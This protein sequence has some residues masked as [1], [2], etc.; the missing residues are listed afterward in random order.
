MSEYAILKSVFVARWNANTLVVVITTGRAFH[1]RGP[2]T[3]KALFEICP[4][5]RYVKLAGVCGSEPTAAGKRRN[6]S[7]CVCD[8]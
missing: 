5:A 4:G 7:S 1:S 6:S 8:V 2:A 3:E